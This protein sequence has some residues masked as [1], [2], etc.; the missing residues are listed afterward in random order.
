MVV[1]NDGDVL[2]TCN[3]ITCFSTIIFIWH[4]LRELAQSKHELINIFDQIGSRLL[5]SSNEKCW[6]FSVSMVPLNDSK[7]P[8]N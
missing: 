1:T 5:N 4:A 6:G 3:S 7:I 2:F 8:L